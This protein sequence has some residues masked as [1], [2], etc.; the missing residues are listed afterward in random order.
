[1]TS[2]AAADLAT[3]RAD[4]EAAMTSTCTIA[5]R[6]RMVWDGTK[7]TPQPDQPYYDG[8]CSVQSGARSITPVTETGGQQVT[9]GRA[10]IKLPWHVDQIEEGH[11][12]V[13]TA[14]NDPR[15]IGRTFT[16]ESVEGND[17]ATARR[18]SVIDHQG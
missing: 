6:I 17:W 12:V 10:V 2:P 7:S 4:H 18:L 15:W 8:P 13:V 3:M 11:A 1:M 9:T 14:S 16:V 5:P